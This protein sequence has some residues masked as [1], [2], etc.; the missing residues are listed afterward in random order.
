M[1]S[2]VFAPRLEDREIDP[3]KAQVEGWLDH[4]SRWWVMPYNFP[5]SADAYDFMQELA[6]RNPGRK[7]RL[8]SS[9]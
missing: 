3:T 8:S 7:F 5:T 9:L 6:R 2:T 1:T 4:E